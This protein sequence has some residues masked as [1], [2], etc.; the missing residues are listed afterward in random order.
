MPRPR[1]AEPRRKG[2]ARAMR[3]ALLVVAVLTCSFGEPAAAAESPLTLLWDAPAGCPSVDD[4]RASVEKRLGGSLE[5]EPLEA[6]AVVTRRG[7]TSWQVVLSTQQAG[8]SGQ[9]TLEG[10]SCAAVAS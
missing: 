2:K 9:R 6:Q 1:K 10:R 4:V 7:E 5:G 3:L 8:A